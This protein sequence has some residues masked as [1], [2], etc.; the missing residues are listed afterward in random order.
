MKGGPSAAAGASLWL[1]VAVIAAAGFVHLSLID[2][3][4]LVGP[5]VV[6]PLGID[7][8]PVAEPRALLRAARIV[9]PMA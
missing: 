3:L 9:Q 4:L 6:V 1:L 5:L 7:L 8:L 2:V